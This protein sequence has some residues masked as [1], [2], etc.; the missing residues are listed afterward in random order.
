[1]ATEILQQLWHAT[2]F[3][4]KEVMSNQF[5]RAQRMGEGSLHPHPKGWGI[6]DP[7]RSLF[8]KFH[9]YNDL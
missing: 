3:I 1:V 7:P 6:R 4:L 8:I 9:W 2:N 5:E